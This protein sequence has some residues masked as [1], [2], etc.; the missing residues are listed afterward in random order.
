MTFSGFR[1]MIALLGVAVILPSSSDTASPNDALSP[2]PEARGDIDRGKAY[3]TTCVACHG[4]YGEGNIGMNAPNLTQLD[5]DYLERQLRHYR[6]QIRG[7]VEDFYG[8]QMNGRANALPEDQSVDDVVAYILTLPT[9]DSE[10]TLRH[11]VAEG[12]EIYS[13]ECATCHGNIGEGNLE[14]Q[15]PALT[16]LQDWYVLRQLESYRSGMRGSHEKDKPGMQ[17]QS[18]AA[19]L[20]TDQSLRSVSTY[21]GTLKSTER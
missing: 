21:I 1:P 17:M 9:A 2:A 11:P 8:W 7:G 13:T 15:S 19:A 18:F 20:D 16:G 4:V 6:E 10:E 5:R 12:E 3:F 14:L